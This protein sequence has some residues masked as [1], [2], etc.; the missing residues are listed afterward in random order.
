MMNLQQIFHENHIEIVAVVKLFQ[1][2][3]I[4]FLRDIESQL[5]PLGDKIDMYSS[6]QN[7]RNELK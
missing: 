7:D 4:R 1:S 5:L 2:L 6:C 3:F